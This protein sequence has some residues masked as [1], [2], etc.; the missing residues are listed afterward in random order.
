MLLESANAGSSIRDVLTVWIS[1]MRTHFHTSIV[2]HFSF[3][4]L[5]AP[6]V[7]M[8]KTAPPS[9]FFPPDAT[10]FEEIKASQS[11]GGG[12]SKLSLYVSVKVSLMMM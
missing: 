11:D 4:G 2:S 8:M 10:Q 1:E 3:L 12:S 6:S 7:S 5:F 9:N